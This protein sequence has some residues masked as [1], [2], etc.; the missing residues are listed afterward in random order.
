[1][2][3][4]LDTHV[5]LWWLDDNPSLSPDARSAIADPG[6]GVHVSSV[7]I[8]EIVIKSGKGKLEI[9]ADWREVIHEEPFRQLPITWEHTLKVGELPAVHQDPFDRLLVAQ[10]LVEN[11]VLV[12]HDD[13]LE[14]YG[15]KLLKT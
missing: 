1:M 12:T 8:W 6:N 10:S 9:P 14:Q 15:A 11:L 5:L 13:I 3:L 7:N 4:L 2:N